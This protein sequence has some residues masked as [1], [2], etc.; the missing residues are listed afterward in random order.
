MTDDVF[1]RDAKIGDAAAIQAM[2]V[3]LA[4]DMGTPGAAKSTVETIEAHGFGEAPDFRVVI[5]EAKGRPIG[6]ALYFPEFSTWRGK[7]GVFIQDLYVDAAYRSSRVGERL[8]D[9][10]AVRGAARGAVYVKLAVDAAN[11]KAARF[12]ERL[13]FKEAKSDRIMV[14]EGAA[15]DAARKA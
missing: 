11:D 14:L 2:L 7:R 4:N 10:V 12:Y 13:G 3:G 6:L 1:I 15:F 9:A 8:V 5:A